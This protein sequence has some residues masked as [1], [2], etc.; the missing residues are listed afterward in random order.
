MKKPLTAAFMTD[1]NSPMRYEYCL[2]L[3]IEPTKEEF[4]EMSR[5]DLENAVISLHQIVRGMTAEIADYKVKANNLQQESLRMQAELEEKE[6]QLYK[7]IRS[8]NL[9]AM[10]LKE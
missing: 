3:E 8:A 7:L 2:Y 1:K 9:Q 10:Q 4:D 5:S 6:R